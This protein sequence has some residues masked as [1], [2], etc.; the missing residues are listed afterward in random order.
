M[1]I[2][3]ILNSVKKVSKDLITNI[4][5]FD[6]YQG[7]NIDADK[8]SVAFS[9]AIQPK[10]KVLTTEEIDA[11]SDKIIQEITTKFKGILRDK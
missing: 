10:E 11:I 8:K 5:L 7:E 2:G 1:E 9:I 6:I 4:N 3:N